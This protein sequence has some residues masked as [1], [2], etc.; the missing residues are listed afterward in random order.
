MPRKSGRLGGVAGSVVKYVNYS[1]NSYY[2]ILLYLN[3]ILYT[4][5]P[6]KSIIL[7]IAL[8]TPYNVA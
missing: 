4:I 8:L 5:A 3:S 6:Y 1:I 2:F 7:L